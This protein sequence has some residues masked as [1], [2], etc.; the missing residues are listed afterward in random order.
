MNPNPFTL[1]EQRHGAGAAEAAPY[2][3]RGYRRGGARP[4]E[5]L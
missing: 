4:F 1:A 5:L 3:R 2:V